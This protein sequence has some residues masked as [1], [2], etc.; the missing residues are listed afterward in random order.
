VNDV[1]VSIKDSLPNGIFEAKVWVDFLSQAIS[2]SVGAGIGA[3]I[4]AR[5][6]FGLERRRAQDDRELAANSA[7]AIL[8]DQRTTSGNLA[9]LT[10]Q[11]ISSDL[12]RYRSQVLEPALKRVSPWFWLA[13]TD[14]SETSFHTFDIPSL[15]FLLNT[16]NP[17]ILLRLSTEAEHNTAFLRT[18][19]VRSTFHQGHVVPILERLER[20]RPGMKYTDIE[21]REAVGKRIYFT[22]HNWF[23]DIENLWDLNFKTSRE[24]ANELSALLL[25]ILPG[26][27]IIDFEKKA[28]K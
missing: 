6:A 23:S 2:A 4:G 8:A 19:Q 26:K 17:G 27:R 24:T 18:I 14:V 7:A 12:V 5:S 21:L 28:V 16:R 13:P 1:I 9:I 3:L 20:D 25:E 11:M 15:S 10:L 22:L